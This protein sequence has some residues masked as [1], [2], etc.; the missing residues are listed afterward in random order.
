MSNRGHGTS[1][2]AGGGD[3]KLDVLIPALLSVVLVLGIQTRSQSYPPVRF[4]IK[5]FTSQ[6]C[7]ILRAHRP[8]GAGALSL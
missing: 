3:D 1:S 8:A 6:A 7:Q 5:T 4:V 2:Y